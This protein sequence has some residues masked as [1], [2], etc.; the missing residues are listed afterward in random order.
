MLS[1][2]NDPMIRAE[3][4]SAFGNTLFAVLGLSL[5]Y[6]L[7]SLVRHCRTGGK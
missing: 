6:A 4:L 1:L 2:F 7:V 3:L 5:A